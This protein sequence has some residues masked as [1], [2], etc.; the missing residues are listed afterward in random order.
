VSA[1]LNPE[2]ARDCPLC[3]RLVAYRAGE[4]SVLEL[5]DSQRAALEAELTAI[6]LDAQARSAAI[7][8]DQLTAQDTP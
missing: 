8:L 6:D 5:I 2:P 1:A 4:S 7:H 3:P